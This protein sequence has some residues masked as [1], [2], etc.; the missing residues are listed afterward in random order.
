MKNCFEFDD[1]V[2]SNNSVR[3]CIKFGTIWQISS[4][5]YA[6]YALNLPL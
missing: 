1:N 5:Y 6:G 4:A 3:D 2:K